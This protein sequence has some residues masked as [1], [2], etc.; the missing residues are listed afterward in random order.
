MHVDRR[1]L[2]WGLFFIIV[3]TI[4]LAT[5]AG[6]L[7]PALVRG[8][9]TLWPLLLV[10]WGIGLVLRRTRL[11][12]LGGAA[13][14][15]VLGL[16]GGGLLATGFSGGAFSAGCGSQT[17][18]TAFATQQGTAAA[19]TTMNV[20]FN[21]GILTL[22]AADGPT[23]SVSGTE[24]RGDAPDIRTEGASVTIAS[25]DHGSFFGAGGRRT[26]WTVVV[27]RSPVT[28]LGITINAGQST[29]NL[30]G[31]NLGDVALTVNAGSAWMDLSHA[32]ALGGLRAT[33]NAGSGTIVMPFDARAAS[34][35]LNAGSMNLCLAAAT[36]L[37]LAWSGALGSNNLD[38]S[39]LT[40]VDAN[41]W[42]STSFNPVSSFL[43]LRVT[44]NAGSFR[45]DTDGTC[46]A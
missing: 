26:D 20:D 10:A 8:W 38:A 37:R 6:V 43:D 42:Q 11:D 19:T 5:R 36:P 27:P 13:A 25:K 24:T 35:S 1:L 30:E 18:G 4:A 40:K 16:M 39:G 31:A 33:V 22:Q 23:W 7:D 28:N 3:G 14:A 21:C 44:A 34:L 2:G 12:W 29:G 15:V 17:P 9:V 32:A 46:D 41:T 45:L